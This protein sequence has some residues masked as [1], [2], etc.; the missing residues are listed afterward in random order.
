M[1]GR[2]FTGQV[3]LDLTAGLYFPEPY[4]VRL[5]M[6]VLRGIR[7][8]VEDSKVTIHPTDLPNV[9]VTKEKVDRTDI[10][11]HAVEMPWDDRG[12]EAIITRNYVH[13]VHFSLEGSGRP[14][15]IATFLHNDR[16]VEFDIDFG[17]TGE[18]ATEDGPLIPEDV[19]ESRL[20]QVLDTI[21]P[22]WAV[23]GVA[24]CPPDIEEVLRQGRGFEGGA[25]Y[26]G[27]SLTKSVGRQRLY[28]V[29]NTAASLTD[30]RNGGLYISWARPQ[31]RER[32]DTRYEEFVSLLRG[33]L[34]L[35]HRSS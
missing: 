1:R 22:F 24:A 14:V 30:L 31:P 35:T 33:T 8:L 32:P 19:G 2:R 5:H 20:H 29:L 4:S 12:L 18:E 23:V 10:R 16:S 17:L 25:A 9:Q 11:G 6:L 7:E 15:T 27:S 26:I 21:D 28:G 34:R 3:W 13:W